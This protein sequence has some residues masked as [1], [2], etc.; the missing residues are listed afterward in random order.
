[1]ES[2]TSLNPGPAFYISGFNLGRAAVLLALF[3]VMIT[4]L[5][6]GMYEV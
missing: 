6:A 2:Y 5:N 3:A 4:T 1:V